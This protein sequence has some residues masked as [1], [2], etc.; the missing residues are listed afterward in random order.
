M[1]LAYAAG[2][3][4]NKPTPV[5]RT[6]YFL[7]YLGDSFASI[8]EPITRIEKFVAKV[9]NELIETPDP[10][11]RVERILAYIV[12]DNVGV[13]VPRTREEIFLLDAANYIKQH[14]G[15]IFILSYY[16]YDG[17]TLLYSERV[18]E[19]ADGAGYK[20][21]TPSKPDT[22]RY[23]YSFIGWNT[24]PNSSTAESS[25]LKNI[26]EDRSVYAAFSEAEKTFTVYFYN[27]E[28]LL[29]TVNNVAYGGTAAYSG[30]APD[31]PN[32]VF[33]GWSPSNTNITA[34]T[35]CYAQF[36]TLQETITDSWQEIID[37]INDGTY[38]SKYA[39]GDT[40]ILDLGTEE[41]TVME[42]VA[43]DTD[44]LTAGNGTAPITWISKYLLKTN[45]KMNSYSSGYL[46][47]WDGS[48]MKSYLRNTIMPRMPSEVQHAIVSV[49]KYTTERATSTTNNV[50]VLS[51]E[52]VWI[53]SYRELI[54]DNTVE[55]TGVT[56][57]SSYSTK[58]KRTRTKI[59]GAADYWW[60][61]SAS[62]NSNS[63][64][65]YAFAFVDSEGNVSSAG[66]DC[67]YA[68]GVVLGFCLGISTYAAN[69]YNQ[70]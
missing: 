54:G 53:P 57:T 25:A 2:E 15:N 66:R 1:F 8:P 48:E 59:R 61:R 14:S 11:T 34:D 58:A 22:A 42:I 5:T 7:N 51:D 49:K 70:E 65:S 3:D 16:N 46:A 35:S 9:H 20:G 62:I 24:S 18:R 41:K 55:T 6:E 30:A 27:G 33:N 45:R 29:Q 26:T 60:L 47:K 19:G 28:T 32:G 10:V 63:G 52:T 69:F 31:K 56:Y 68:R 40:K 44:V 38:S 23:T 13:P 64:F 39:V 21:A 12:D 43:I 17:S 37:N 67:S 50:D 4:V 36:I